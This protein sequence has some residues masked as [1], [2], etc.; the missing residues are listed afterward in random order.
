MQLFVFHQTD[1]CDSVQYNIIYVPT[2]PQS[3]F[4]DQERREFTFSLLDQAN[5]NALIAALYV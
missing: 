1:Q 5:V 3:I 2:E 4:T